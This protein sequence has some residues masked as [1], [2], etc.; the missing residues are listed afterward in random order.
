[1]R[2]AGSYYKKGSFLS[3]GNTWKEREGD[4]PKSSVAL[5]WILG[6]PQLWLQEL[7]A[8]GPAWPLLQ[9]LVW[10]PREALLQ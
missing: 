8:P 7:A 9:Y 2:W 1:M 6:Y 5:G 10:G 3:P 4:V